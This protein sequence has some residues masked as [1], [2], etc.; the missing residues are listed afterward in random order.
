MFLKRF[1]NTLR[2]WQAIFTQLLL[3]LLF[4]LF[5]LI[6]A[7]TLPNE[8]ENDPSRSLRISNSGLDP[9]N[10]IMFYAEFGDDPTRAFDFSVSSV[11][12]IHSVWYMY[13]SCACTCSCIHCTITCRVLWVQVPPEAA[14]FS[15]DSLGCAVLLCLV[16]LTLLASS[17]LLISH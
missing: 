8:N 5:A 4:V 9:N 16:C 7:V 10:R 13:Y 3:P 6:L 14:H 2:F 17:F 11:H 1:Y 15:S 12:V